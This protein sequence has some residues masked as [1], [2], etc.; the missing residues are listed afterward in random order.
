MQ[1]ITTDSK[2]EVKNFP[3]SSSIPRVSFS[4]GDPLSYFRDSGSYSNVVDMIVSRDRANR[5]KTGILAQSRAPGETFEDN[6]TENGREAQ[7]HLKRRSG[8]CSH[9]EEGKH[10]ASVKRVRISEIDRVV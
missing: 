4:K 2:D 10:I 5:R 1:S 8:D 6:R 3:L 7:G 9:D